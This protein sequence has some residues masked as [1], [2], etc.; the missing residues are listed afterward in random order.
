MEKIGEEV[1]E[2]IDIVPPKIQVLRD[3]RLKYA[4]K[5]EECGGIDDP[6][7]AVKISP[8]PPQIIP[9]GIVTVGMLVYVIISRFADHRW[10][11]IEL[12]YPGR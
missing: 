12:G 7:G 10:H 6:E 3:I 9:Q 1:S 4:C 5:Q 11:S 2:R 8:L